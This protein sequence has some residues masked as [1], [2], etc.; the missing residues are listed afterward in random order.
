[1]A[2]WLWKH[3]TSSGTLMT[4]RPARTSS[5]SRP[6]AITTTTGLSRSLHLRGKQVRTQYG[7]I[8]QLTSWDRDPQLR[9]VRQSVS[10]LYNARGVFK[11]LSHTF[12]TVVRMEIH[13][14]VM[15]QSRFEWRLAC[16]G[17]IKTDQLDVTCFIISL[18]TAQHVSNV[19]TSIFRSLRLICSYFIGCIA[20]V[21][22]VLVLGV[23]RL[24]WCGTLMQAEAL[25]QPA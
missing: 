2:V 17:W 13:L 10:T 18:F 20:L 16:H 9:N 4:V 5:A 8:W 21:R 25:L 19:S 1:M 11:W 24:G 23:V 3:Q 6:D 7:T 22:R 15:S 14:W 12:N